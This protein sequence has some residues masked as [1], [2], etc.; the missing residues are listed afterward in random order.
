MKIRMDWTAM[1]VKLVA[2]KEVA[3]ELAEEPLRPMVKQPQPEPV[4]MEPVPEPR[5]VQKM[6]ARWAGAASTSRHRS[7]EVRQE[8]LVQILTER[9]R[10]PRRVLQRRLGWSRSTLRN[11]LW[12]VTSVALPG[13]PGDE[14]EAG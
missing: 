4:V 7:A 2:Q 6:A 11:V 14:G 10:M 13:L 3:A 9:G 12:P 5:Q 1:R 8:E